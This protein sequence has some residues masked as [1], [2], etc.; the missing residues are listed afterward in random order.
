MGRAVH[1]AAFW[2]IVLYVTFGLIFSS[3]LAYSVPATNLLGRAYLAA[4][5]PCWIKAS[6]CAG[7]LPVSKAMFTLRSADHAR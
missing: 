5:W 4:T 6:P 7:A 2:A 1:I 3:A